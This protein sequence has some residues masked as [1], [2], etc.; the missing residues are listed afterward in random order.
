MAFKMFWVQVSDLTL[1]SIKSRYRRTFAGFIWVILNPLLMFGVQ[2]LVFKKFLKLQIPEYY[3][4][5]LGGL[6]PWIFISQ[7]IQM[8]TPVFISQAHLLKS[9]K[10]NPLVLI[11]SQVLDNFINFLAS[12][13]IILLPFFLFSDRE[14]LNLIYMPL[15]LIPLLVATMGFTISLSLLNVFY[16]DIN[17]IMGFVFSLLFFI[18]P[19][20]YPRGFVPSD[21]QWMVDWNPFTYLIE[22]FRTLLWDPTMGNFWIK[23]LN[24]LGIAT[25]SCLFAGYTWHRRR[26]GFYRKL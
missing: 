18:T 8:G 6:L 2:S 9:F 16:R 25:L 14:A 24:S 19:I 13:A 10:I 20:F 7:T 26:N 15:V 12:F 1:A 23:Y 11:A 4:Y 5:L 3:L 21:W 22:P 17:F